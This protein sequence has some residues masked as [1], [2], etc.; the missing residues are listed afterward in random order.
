MSNSQKVTEED[1]LKIAELARLALRN[2]EVPLFTEQFNKILNYMD[3][4]NEL[5]TDGVGPLSHVLDLANNT[6]EDKPE[7]SL[8]Q[9]TVLSLAP[10]SKH[11]HV[12][13]PPVIQKN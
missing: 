4:L 8:D 5:D 13:V 3:Q 11:G 10:K 12:A 9:E 7:K 2:D 1:V 6:R